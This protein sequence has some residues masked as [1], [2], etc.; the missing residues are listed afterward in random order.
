[1][2]GEMSSLGRSPVV[3]IGVEARDV[4]DTTGII[5]LTDYLYSYTIC[6]VKAQ[7]NLARN[8][9]CCTEEIVLFSS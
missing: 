6:P 9:K 3:E 8:R 5:S 4:Q 7:E 1:M 2:W